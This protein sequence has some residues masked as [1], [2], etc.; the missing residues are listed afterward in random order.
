MN[1]KFTQ[2]IFLGISRALSFCPKGLLGSSDV[3]ALKH[4]P[5]GGGRIEAVPYLQNTEALAAI[6]DKKLGKTVGDLVRRG[7]TPLLQGDSPATLPLPQIEE[8][9]KLAEVSQ[10]KIFYLKKERLY[11]MA[12]TI[13]DFYDAPHNN[14]REIEELAS[15][16]DLP[17]TLN[18][19]GKNAL[20]FLSNPPANIILIRDKGFFWVW[21]GFEHKPAWPMD[22]RG[23]LQV[24]IAQIPEA[25]RVFQMLAKKLSEAGKSFAFK[26]LVGN[27]HIATT[28]KN[29]GKAVDLSGPRKLTGFYDRMSP[30]EPVIALYAKSKE[31]ILE[32]LEQLS[33]MPEWQKIE[34]ERVFQSRREGASAYTNKAGQEFRTLCY[35]EEAGCAED[36]VKA[37]AEEGGWRSQV[38]GA[39]TGLLV[40]DDKKEKQ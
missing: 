31:E 14:L 4:I 36:F 18:Q 13:E 39:R 21:A 26:F 1:F 38:K 23:Y 33:Q 34:S 6:I 19:E 25:V 9:Q 10:K 27:V 17:T 37:A 28:L 32:I 2:P 12:E 7:I 5:R 40:L 22:H 15:A 8:L 16:A 30:S 11:V 3:F 24:D 35:L 20:R 29:A